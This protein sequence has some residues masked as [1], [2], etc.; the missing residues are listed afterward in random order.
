MDKTVIIS[1][2]CGGIG[3]S[4]VRRF[5]EN[6]WGVISLDLK[7]CISELEYIGS[8]THISADITSEDSIKGLVQTLEYKYKK[9]LLINSIVNAVGM[10]SS[11]DIYTTTMED[12]YRV[13]DNNLIA[14]FLV[15]KYFLKY[16]TSGGTIVN[17]TSVNAWFPQKNSLAYN[18]SKGAVISLTK[19][20][21]RDLGEKGIRV[22]CVAPGSV[23][24]PPLR[25]YLKAN[26]QKLGKSEEILLKELEE[27]F[28]LYRIGK[29]EEIADVVYFLASDMSSFIT[30]SVIVSDGGLTIKNDA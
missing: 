23:D 21:A 20:L 29:P 13:L 2:G 8:V 25:N 5:A 19:S 24:T 30:G 27:N 14:T 15:I 28:V 11:G 9:N 26:S 6:G 17:L 7:D 1:G 10:Y 12:F 4:I 3:K 18:I 22:N 16:M